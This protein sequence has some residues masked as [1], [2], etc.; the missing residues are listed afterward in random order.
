M[1][2]AMARR[3]AEIAEEKLI[4]NTAFSVP[5]RAKFPCATKKAP[6]FSEWGF[7]IYRLHLL[8]NQVP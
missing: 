6:L 4:P 3:G 7:F 8:H 5:L 2:R 1:Q